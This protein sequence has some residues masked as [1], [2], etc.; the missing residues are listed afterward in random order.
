MRQSRVVQI[1]IFEK[2]SQHEFGM[3]L[4]QLS[5]I[6]DR[7]PEILDLIEQDLIDTLCK[8]TGRNGLA[9]EAIFRCLLLKQHLRCSYE[10]LAFHL[11]TPQ[12]TAPSLGCLILY[13]LADQDCNL[14]FVK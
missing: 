3:R 14:L 6:L 2:Y 8:K 4:E 5:K 13:A 9:V 12:V 1:S 10:Q 7:Y 11:S